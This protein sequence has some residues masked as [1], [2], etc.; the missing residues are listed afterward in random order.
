MFTTGEYP[1][2]YNKC[3]PNG[4]WSNTDKPP[5]CKGITEKFEIQL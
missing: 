4:Q 3:Q 1:Y 5:G 2:W